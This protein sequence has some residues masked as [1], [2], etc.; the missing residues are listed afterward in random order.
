MLLELTIVDIAVVEV[1]D[2]GVEGVGVGV[3]GA[4]DRDRA[5]AERVRKLTE[6]YP[7]FS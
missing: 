1:G 2:R 4:D 7:A 6:A 5:G 3:R